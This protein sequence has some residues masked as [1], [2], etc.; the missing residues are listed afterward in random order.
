VI[1]PELRTSSGLLNSSLEYD[2]IFLPL[3]ALHSRHVHSICVILKR[4][5]LSNWRDPPR[6]C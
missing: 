6:H 2:G 1:K 3:I 5:F 4:I